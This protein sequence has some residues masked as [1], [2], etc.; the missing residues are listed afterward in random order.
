MVVPIEFPNV[1]RST[2]QRA[3]KAGAEASRKKTDAFLKS[4]TKLEQDCCQRLWRR[5]DART[6]SNRTS[7]PNGP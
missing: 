6:T 7:L 3:M 1:A 5:L 2:H 4:I